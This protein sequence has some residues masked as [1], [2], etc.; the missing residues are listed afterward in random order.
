MTFATLLFLSCTLEPSGKPDQNPS[1]V[2]PD[3]ELTLVEFTESNKIF[4]NP[5]R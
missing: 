3:E 5:E 1:E 4:A 2:I